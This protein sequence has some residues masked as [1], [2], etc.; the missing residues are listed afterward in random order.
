MFGSKGEIL[1]SD[2][3]DGDK[4]NMTLD[5]SNR[6]TQPTLD[7]RNS[8]RFS[9]IDR[10]TGQSF[11]KTTMNQMRSTYE[12]QNENKTTS[13]RN[14]QFKK[15]SVEK[16]QNIMLEKTFTR[17]AHIANFMKGINE[18]PKIEVKRPQVK[19]IKKREV[20]LLKG[21]TD[22]LN[23]SI[24]SDHSSIFKKAN[25]NLTGKVSVPSSSDHRSN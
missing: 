20:L 4:M 1:F 3:E 13:S 7:A 15:K 5:D 10:N 22:E 9:S 18:L 25:R 21:Q 17:Q 24:G 12:T 14:Q 8:Y 16:P 6:V 23:A 11:S 2:D 19:H